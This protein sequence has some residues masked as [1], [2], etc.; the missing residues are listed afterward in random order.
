MPLVTDL[1]SQLAL[2]TGGTGGIGQATARALADLHCNVAVHFNSA[3]DKAKN[4]VD[5]L[6]QLGVHAQAFQAD[7]SSYDETRRLHK[8]VTESMGQ[9]TILFNNAGLTLGKSGIKDISE[10]SIEDFEN[11]WR[12][13]T[14]SAYL[15][16]QLCM[17]SMVDAGFG[18]VI[19]CSS[20]A[21]LSGGIVGPHYASSK[22][23]LHGLV[24]WLANTYAKKGITVNA[25]A[26]ALITDTAMLPG[27]S[28]TLASKIPIGRL[29][30]PEEIAET[31]LWMVKTGYVTNKV[32]AVD[33]GLF[34]Q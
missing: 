28:E 23:A 14:G 30:K 19:F 32:V 31:V 5:E 18:R 9:P 1:S 12:A 29:G 34:V 25:I 26:P 21:G 16:T 20:V 7:L 15:L 13:N 3:G 8:E 2:I 22:S 11:T 24:H 4:L 6:Q 27:S 33:G 10:I 17:P